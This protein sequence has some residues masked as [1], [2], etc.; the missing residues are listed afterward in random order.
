MSGDVRHF[1]NIKTRTIIKFF[2]CK[3]RRWR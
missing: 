1:N 3:A 2:S